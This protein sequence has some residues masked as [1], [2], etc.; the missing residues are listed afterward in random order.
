MGGQVNTNTTSGS[1]NFDGSILSVEQRNTTAGFSIVLYTGTGA[2][3]TI[4]HG[5][6]TAPQWIII[7]RRDSAQNWVV[8]HEDVGNQRQTYLNLGDA[9]SGTNSVYFNNTSP[10]STVFSLGSDSYAN[11]SS[12]TYVAYC[13]AE[14][15]G[16]S[17]FGSYTGNGS[18]DGAFVFTGFRPAWIMLKRTDSADDWIMV[19]TTRATINDAGQT[20][21][22][23]LSDAETDYS[24][25]M[26]IVS[27]GFKLR[28]N[29]GSKNASSG[30]YIYMA[31]AEQPFKFANAR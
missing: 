15:E 9:Q 16:Y 8:Y 20:L 4:G 22:A 7:K 13:F 29:G 14:V 19:D 6:S 30:S 10:T 17:K 28:N 11:A 1:T 26:D 3:V 2:N 24:T 25:Q 23:N 27:N 5:A 18:S 12:G 31:F 21:F